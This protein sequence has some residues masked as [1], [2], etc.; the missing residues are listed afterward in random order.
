MLNT[1]ESWGRGVARWSISAARALSV[2][3]VKMVMVL[4]AN[5]E[6]NSII[7]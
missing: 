3:R 4:H 5:I 7:V 2:E 6:Y 1:R